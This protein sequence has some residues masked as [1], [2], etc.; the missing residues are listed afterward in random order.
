MARNVRKYEPEEV[1]ILLVREDLT[2][3]EVEG[4]I[5]AAC[6]AL[7]TNDEGEDNEGAGPEPPMDPEDPYFPPHNYPEAYKRMRLVPRVTGDKLDARP[8]FL[9]PGRPD[10]S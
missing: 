2:P 6:E 8:R 4:R 9:L 1:L 3:A 7:D 5:K 10:F